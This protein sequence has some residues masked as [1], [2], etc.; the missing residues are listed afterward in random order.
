MKNFVVILLTVAILLCTTAYADMLDRWIFDPRISVEVVDR[1]DD[2]GTY[3]VY[4][5]IAEE[6]VITLDRD[7]Y[8]DMGWLSLYRG[9]LNNCRLYCECDWGGQE[10]S[11]KIINEWIGMA[12]MM[13]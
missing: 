7:I 2:N 10:E 5:S 4:Y 8:N 6:F 1:V 11:E 3:S 12:L 9:D 13:V